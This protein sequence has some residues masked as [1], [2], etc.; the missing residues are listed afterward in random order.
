MNSHIVDLIQI[1][2]VQS[3]SKSNDHYVDFSDAEQPTRRKQEYDLKVYVNQAA[4]S[5]QHSN[6]GKN[7][8]NK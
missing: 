3:I 5:A 8:Q 4:E 1:L 6:I 2:R 7:I